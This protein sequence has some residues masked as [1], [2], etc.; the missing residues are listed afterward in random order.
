MERPGVDAAPCV[1]LLG[2]L[3]TKGPACRYL[4]DRLRDHG[5]TVVMVDASYRPHRETGGDVSNQAVAEAGGTSLEHVAA[6][7]RRGAAEP[8]VRGAA[9]VVK[10]LHRRGRCHGVMAVGGANGTLLAS[11]AMAGLPVGLPK[12]VVSAVGLAGADRF[13]AAPDVAV[14]PSIGDIRLNRITARVF[15]NAASAMAAMA[16]AAAGNLR[17]AGRAAPPWWV[18]RCSA[19]PTGRPSGRPSAWR[20]PDSR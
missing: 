3:D 10:D 16:R 15:D 9:T 13:V 1:V 19:S 11:G 4:R 6:L 12:L 5:I 8:M 20:P 18:S 14:F 2:T 17:G 7:D